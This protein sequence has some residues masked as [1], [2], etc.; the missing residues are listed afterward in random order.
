MRTLT[1]ARDHG[2][3]F[4]TEG[5]KATGDVAF[6]ARDFDTADRHY[7][8][9]LQR[10]AEATSD[11][12]LPATLLG[13]LFSNR[14]GT[15]AQ[16]NRHQEALEDGR[17]ALKH[18]PGW[19]RAVCRVGAALISL[20]RFDEARTTSRARARRVFSLRAHVARARRARAAS[21]ARFVACPLIRF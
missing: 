13:A 4:E 17:M 12:P 6:K 3:T 7:T 19:S 5:L 16:L 14:S 1:V 15:R 11:E 21:C 18:R 9:A 2:E 10:A 20:R 8:S